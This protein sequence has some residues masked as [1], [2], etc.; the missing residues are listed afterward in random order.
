MKKTLLNILLLAIVSFFSLASYADTIHSASKDNDI[1]SYTKM[2]NSRLVDN[3]FTYQHDSTFVYTRGANGLIVVPPVDWD[4]L[5]YNVSFRDTIIYDPLFLPV[6]FDGKILPPRLDFRS[7]DTK[8]ESPQYHLI[9]Q[10]STFAPLIKRT[11]LIQERRKSFYM[12][13]N[14]IGDVKYNTFVLNSLPKLNE[15]DVTKR[16]F[17]NDLITTDDAV[18]IAPIEI[19]KFTPDFIYWTKHGEHSLEA[20]QNY[21]SSN[22]HSGGNNSY[23]I[24]N[25]HKFLVNYKKDKIAFDNVLEWKLNL[26][27]VAKA[28]KHGTNISEDLLRLENTLGYKAFNKWSYSAKLETKT[29]LFN[30]YPVNGDKKNT[31][32]LSP[33]IVNLGIGMNYTLEK[34]FESDKTKKLKISQSLSPLSINYIYLNDTDVIKTSGVEVGEGKSSKIEFGS[35]INTDLTFSF[36]RYMSWTSRFKYFTN[37]ERVEA[38]FEN[39]FVMRLSR[40]LSTTIQVYARFDDR[41]NAEKAKDLGYFQ[42]NEMVSFGF[43]YKW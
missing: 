32:F 11:E 36:N 29:G 21:I 24:K 19:E 1:P 20:S 12:E 3:K 31:A 28:E 35:L 34:K 40:F 22:W 13:M 9:P 2:Y 27:Q 18:Q 16:N 8:Y 14:N 6:V 17:L 25:Y 7:K 42:L 5:P 41:D 33:L 15:E 23:V 4:P 10:D 37:Y 30:S 39:R 43:N 38:E 26:Q